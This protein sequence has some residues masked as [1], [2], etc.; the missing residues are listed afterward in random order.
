MNVVVRKKL[1][2]K[3]KNSASESATI[4]I[5]T[6]RLH[7][8]RVSNKIETDKNGRTKYDT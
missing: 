5:L 3:L 1:S 2:R 7:A 8:K 4:L 6:V